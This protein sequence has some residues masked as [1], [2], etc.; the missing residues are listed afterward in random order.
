ML[1]SILLKEDKS[2]SEVSDELLE[3]WPSSDRGRADCGF[4]CY[5]IDD[6]Q[7]LN[8]GLN[9]STGKINNGS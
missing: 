1:F 2:L 3:L 9:S 6:T 8:E 5:V 4:L 7:F